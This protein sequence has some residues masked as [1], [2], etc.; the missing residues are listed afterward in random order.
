MK[1][2]SVEPPLPAVLE[3]SRRGRLLYIILVPKLPLGNPG[4]RQALLG[5][6][7]GTI[8]RRAV[9]AARFSCFAAG[10][11]AHE[12]LSWIFLFCL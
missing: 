8:E 5:S 3:K 7:A 1:S 9:P 6:A 10:P 2:F 11:P 12:E 4:A